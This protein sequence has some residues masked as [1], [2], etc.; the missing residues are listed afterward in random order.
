M[1]NTRD[2]INIHLKEKLTVINFLKNADNICIN[3]SMPSC[4]I[5]N[6]IDHYEYLSFDYKYYINYF[7]E[8]GINIIW[9]FDEYSAERFLSAARFSH[10]IT[11]HFVEFIY[12]TICSNDELHIKGIGNEIHKYFIL[13]IAQKYCFR[14]IR[15]RYF[16]P[17]IS[18]WKIIQALIYLD[19]RVYLDDNHADITNTRIHY[20]NDIFAQLQDEFSLDDIYKYLGW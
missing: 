9:I 1:N 19:N 17:N 7:R 13:M 12:N 6:L 2:L 5:S 3:C 18:N 15:I 8:I 20:L 14:K 4:Y 16:S 11:D 10:V